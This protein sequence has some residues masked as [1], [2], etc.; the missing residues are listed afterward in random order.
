MKLVAHFG[1]QV[2][3][4]FAWLTLWKEQN[5]ASTTLG[6]MLTKNY[7]NITNML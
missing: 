6:M 4:R 2:T 3:S 7:Q 1:E 5:G